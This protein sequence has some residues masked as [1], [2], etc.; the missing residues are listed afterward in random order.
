MKLLL[1]TGIALL[2]GCCASA[3]AQQKSATLREVTQIPLVMN[4][5]QVGFTTVKAGTV[6]K[7]LQEEGGK[8]LVATLAGQ[9]WVGETSVI[10][11]EHQTVALAA[12]T[13]VKATKPQATI[14]APSPKPTPASP[15]ILAEMGTGDRN[16]HEAR[17]AKNDFLNITKEVRN[18]Q[19][20]TGLA[21]LSVVIIKNFEIY[22]V[23]ASGTGTFKQKKRLSPDD[24]FVIAS[25]SKIFTATLAAICVDKG[26]VRWDSTLE[27]IFPEL[28]KKMHPDYRSVTLVELLSHTAGAPE[29]DAFWGSKTLQDSVAMRGTSR[30]QRIFM[31][32]EITDKRPDLSRGKYVYSNAGYYMA[33]AALEKICNDSWENLI[34][35]EVFTRYNL[36]SAEAV[37][38]IDPLL[39]MPAGGISCTLTDLARFCILHMQKPTENTL[40]SPESFLRLHSPPDGVASEYALG[41]LVTNRDWARGPA[42]THMGMD[43]EFVTV[44]WIS[45]ATGFGVVAAASNLGGGVDAKLDKAVFELIQIFNN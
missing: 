19:H 22:G 6:V 30:E 33:A 41:V 18:A 25:C 15:A 34:K 11:E 7:V 13:P 17:S 4:G 37:S 28:A 36:S 40:V 24:P 10:I 20:G 9:V 29:R 16:H 35:K 38:T 23:G 2:L 44:F 12:P 42:F 5:K 43:R 3:L 8:V 1:F 14:I 32:K 26:L 45:P 21:S 39:T 31:F 27:E